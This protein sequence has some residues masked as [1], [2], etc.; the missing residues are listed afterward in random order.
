MRPCLKARDIKKEVKAN[1]P[2]IDP[3]IFREHFCTDCPYYAGRYEKV[4]RCMQK[5]CAWDDEAELFSPA[6]QELLPV[7]EEEFQK[8]EAKY[9]EA[10]RKRDV[11]ISMF[12][13]EMQEIKRR[14]DPCYEC[15]YGKVH[16]CIG[17]CYKQMTANPVE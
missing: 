7:F 4:P 16:P 5:N 11:L 9:L 10:K 6:L 15:P 8:A 14:K 17:F 1:L 13:Q 12:K 3:V 2:V